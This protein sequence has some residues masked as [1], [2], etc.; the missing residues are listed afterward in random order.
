MPAINVLEPDDVVLI[1]IGARLDLDQEGRIFARIGEAMLLADRDVGGLILAQ[2]F[3][4]LALGD[5]EGALTTTQCSER[6]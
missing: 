6:W 5:L 1:E 3:D 4:V 2:E